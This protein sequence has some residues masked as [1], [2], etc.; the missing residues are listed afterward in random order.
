MT[1]NER[2]KIVNE[3]DRLQARLALAKR[4]EGEIQDIDSLLLMM[5]SGTM[6]LSDIGAVISCT[7]ADVANELTKCALTAI[8]EGLQGRRRMLVDSYAAI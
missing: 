6:S 7:R 8:V 2:V 5:K 3:I 4:V 1:E